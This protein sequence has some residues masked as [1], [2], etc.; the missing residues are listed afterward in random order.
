MEPLAYLALGAV[1]GLLIVLGFLVLHLI[2]PTVKRRKQDYLLDRTAYNPDGVEDV[3]FGKLYKESKDG[4]QSTNADIYVSIIVPAMNEEERLPIMIEEA[5][6]YLDTRQTEAQFTWEIIVVDDGSKDNTADVAFSY[7]KKLNNPNGEIRVLKLPQNVGKGGAVRFGV[8][9]SRGQMIL[10]ADAD[11]ATKFSEFE[12]LENEL[13]KLCSDGEYFEY[14]YPAIAIGS[15]AHL[16]AEAIAE[17]SIFRTILS[18]GFQFLVYFFGVKGIK[19]TQ[20]GFKLF[21]R[22][23]AAKLFPLLH[24]ERWAFDVELLYLAEREGFDMVEVAVNWHEVDGSKITPVLSW[25]Q[26]GRDILLMWFRYTFG[27]WTGP[28]YV[29]KV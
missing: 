26:M 12:K 1:P 5:V 24:I 9:V 18:K 25:I 14:N 8:S 16:E 22:A 7:S 4:L 13:F 15:R 23:A 27:L 29:V 20:C 19:D 3:K 11:G 10:F 17:R 6:A 21:S 28:Y 2:T